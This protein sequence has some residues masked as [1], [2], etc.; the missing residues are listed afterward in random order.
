MGG[1]GSDPALLLR[2]VTPKTSSFR[3]T[4]WGGG[5]KF[6]FLALRNLRTLPKRKVIFSFLFAKLVAY[7]FRHGYSRLVR[8]ATQ[9]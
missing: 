3:V 7:N 9:W 4:E 1:G 8:F 5:Q 2:Y 6:A